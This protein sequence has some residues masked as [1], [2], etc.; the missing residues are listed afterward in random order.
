M[1]VM[2]IGV[3]SLRALARSGDR[4]GGG[5]FLGELLMLG[6]ASLLPVSHLLPFVST[7]TADMPPQSNC[8]PPPASR[9]QEDSQLKRRFK[10]VMQLG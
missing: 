5:G 2:D 3:H 10:P 8:A 6:D 4:R 1:W 9:L 7:Q